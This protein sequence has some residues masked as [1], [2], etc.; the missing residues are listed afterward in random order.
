MGQRSLDGVHGWLLDCFD[1]VVSF[2][3]SLNFGEEGG[4]RPAIFEA[5]R[6]AIRRL[7]DLPV[8][9]FLTVDPDGLDFRWRTAIQKANVPSSKTRWSN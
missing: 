7:I 1:A 6:G 2:Q 4:D 8:M 5:S 3:N 9:A